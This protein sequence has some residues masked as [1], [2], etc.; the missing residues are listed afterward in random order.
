MVVN[1]LR[2]QCDYLRKTVD[3]N[4]KDVVSPLANIR[5]AR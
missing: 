3:R 2:V 4:A 5:N 1:Q